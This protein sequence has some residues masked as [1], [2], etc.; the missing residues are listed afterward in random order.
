MGS[1]EMVPAGSGNMEASAPARFFVDAAAHD[2][3]LVPGSPAIDAGV[4]LPTVTGGRLGT[5][6]PTGQHWDTGAFDFSPEA[7]PATARPSRR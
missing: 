2:Y 5:P 4:A 3:P 6:R 7:A 1:A